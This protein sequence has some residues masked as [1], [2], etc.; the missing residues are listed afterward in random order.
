M[1]GE[2]PVLEI[3][4]CDGYEMGLVI[5][6]K[7]SHLIKSRVAKDQVLLNHLLPFSQSPQGHALIQSLSTNNRGMFPRYWDELLGMAHGSGVSFLSILMLNFRKEIIPFLPKEV[8]EEADDCSDVLLVDTSLAIAAH[9][10]D[11]NFSLIGHTYLVKVK[12]LSGLSFTAY[13]YAGELPS[14]AFGFNNHGLAFTLNSVPPTEAEITPGG[15]ARNF[16]SRDLLEASDLN[17]ALH[18]ITMRDVSVGHCYNLV[19]VMS[20]RILNIETASRK[21]VSVREIGG[22]PSFHANMYLHLQVEQVHDDNSLHRQKRA[23]EIPKQSKEEILSVLGDSSDDKYPIY[24]EGPLLHTLCT[25][26]IDLDKKTMSI[27]Q[28][29]PKDKKVSYCFSLS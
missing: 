5:G 9:N 15:I 3:E 13:T 26:L 6:R 23:G 11:A 12:M 27:Y 21:R 16:I 22:T 2:I 7:F 20:R 28:G 25:V 18:R 4:G 24:M 17:E 29:N 19:D 10:E 8:K 1:D 14:C